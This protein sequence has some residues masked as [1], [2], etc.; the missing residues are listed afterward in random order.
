MHAHA[1]L[2][3]HE[4]YAAAVAPGREFVVED[5]GHL[6]EE[7]MIE[8]AAMKT[9]ERGPQRRPEIL[10]VGQSR[11]AKSQNVSPNIGV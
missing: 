1:G 8:I 9:A 5:L 4:A 3:P 10:D 2:L 11:P 7:R 6:D